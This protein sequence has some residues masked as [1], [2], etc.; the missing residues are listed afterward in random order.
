MGRPNS[1]MVI[2][3][4][5]FQKEPQITRLRYIRLTRFLMIP[6]AGES[7]RDRYSVSTEAGSSGRRL[8]TGRAAISAA[9][10]VS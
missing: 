6:N 3:E 7:L 1:F 4:P 10:P 5:V 8:N 2:W 9:S